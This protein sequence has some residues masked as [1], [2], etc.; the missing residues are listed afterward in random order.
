[1]DEG[2]NCEIVRSVL[3]ERANC[4][5][6]AAQTATDVRCYVPLWHPPQRFLSSKYSMKSWTGYGFQMY[7]TLMNCMKGSGFVV[8][9][10]WLFVIWTLADG[11]IFNDGNFSKNCW[12]LFKANK[13]HTWKRNWIC[14][15]GTG[16]NMSIIKCDYISSY[17]LSFWLG[18]QP[19]TS[20][21]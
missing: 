8:N 13:N 1:M 7:S 17:G 9:Q 15:G 21:E 6:L 12:S 18:K 14:F 5:Y 2:I 19:I 11:S 20:L 3:M 10:L 16:L 4:P